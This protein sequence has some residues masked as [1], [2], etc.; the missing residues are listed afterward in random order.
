MSS[1]LF[2]QIVNDMTNYNVER[3]PEYFYFFKKRIDCT[4]R[5]SIILIMK[6][7]AAIRQLAY[8]ST[9]N[10]FDEYLQIGER[11]SRECLLN[12]TK[13]IYILYVEEFLRKPNLDDIE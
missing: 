2:K 8:G 11:R 10:A 12:F 6:C 1:R 13:C 9:P 5:P 3:L 4:G 7:T